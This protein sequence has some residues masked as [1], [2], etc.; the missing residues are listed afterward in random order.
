MPI[1]NSV[2]K[3]FSTWQPKYTPTANTLLYLPFT[4]NMADYSGNNRVVTS[5]LWEIKNWLFFNNTT[6]DKTWLVAQNMPDV[7]SWFTLTFFEK[8]TWTYA[9]T[10]QPLF[11]YDWWNTVHSFDGGS[12]ISFNIWWLDNRINIQDNWADVWRMVTFTYTWSVISLYINNTQISSQSKSFSS[13][14]WNNTYFGWWNAYTPY[15]WYISE[16]IEE[17]YWWTAQQVSDHYNA[18][19][20][21]Y[22]N[23]FP[24]S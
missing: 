16:L 2:Y 10:Q 8:K 17:N 11:R 22:P 3:S 1:F 13:T 7:W 9:N 19:K 23:T 14:W 6:G 20:D 12:W 21:Y 4:E 18:L 5:D 15:Q 24:S